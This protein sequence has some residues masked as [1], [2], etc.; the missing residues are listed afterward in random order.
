MQIN[1]RR[2]AKI[3]RL[4]FMTDTAAS[5]VTRSID[6]TDSVTHRIFNTNV[7]YY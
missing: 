4:H 1:A 2:N 3:N 7:K 6:I 5:R